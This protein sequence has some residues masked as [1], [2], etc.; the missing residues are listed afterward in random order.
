MKWPYRAINCAKAINV[1]HVHDHGR[2]MTDRADAI[3][4][5]THVANENVAEADIV[6]DRRATFAIVHVAVEVAHRVESV[7]AQCTRIYHF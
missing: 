2:E 5:A 4:Q 6:H 7:Q 3:S 1:D